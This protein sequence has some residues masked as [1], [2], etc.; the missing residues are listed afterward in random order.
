M[1]AEISH[2]SAGGYLAN[3]PTLVKI[4]TRTDETMA[5]EAPWVEEGIAVP[6]KRERKLRDLGTHVGEIRSRVALDFRDWQKP[7]NNF[8]RRFDRAHGLS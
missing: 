5:V 4:F 7:R 1:I 6:R 8:S 2:V 3:R